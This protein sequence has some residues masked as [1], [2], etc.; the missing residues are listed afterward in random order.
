MIRIK[1]IEQLDGKGDLKEKLKRL[2]HKTEHYSLQH[3]IEFFINTDS[4][5]M[6]RN[7]AVIDDEYSMKWFQVSF[8]CKRECFI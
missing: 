5:K 8:K 2:F 4:S 3:W 7:Y 1:E 6:G